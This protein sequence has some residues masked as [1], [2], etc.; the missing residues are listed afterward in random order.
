MG[1]RSTRLVSRMGL[2][3]LLTL[4]LLPLGPMSALAT[5]LRDPMTIR[6]NASTGNDITGTGTLAAPYATI[7]K[8]MTVATVVGDVVRVA[9]GTYY[10]PDTITIPTGVQL[11]GA[12]LGR[13]TVVGVGGPNGPMFRIFNGDSNTRLEGFTV[14]GGGGTNGG[15][16]EILGGAS[17]GWGP[18]ITRNDFADCGVSESGGAIF[19]ARVTAAYCKPQIFTNTFRG[20]EASQNGGAICAMDGADPYIYRCTFSGN[21][22]SGSGTQ[23]GGAIYLSGCKARIQRCDIRGNHAPS[24]SG[25]GIAVTT[26]G[27]IVEITETVVYANSA[28]M[29][30]GIWVN[31]APFETVIE[32]CWIAANSG[33]GLGGGMRIYNAPV[34]IDGCTFVGNRKVGGGS[35]GAISIYDL[36]ADQPVTVTSSVFH[37]NGGDDVPPVS[38]FTDITVTYS[39]L[40]EA[41]TGTGNLSG[42]DPLLTRV[43]PYLERLDTTSSCIDAGDPAS[44]L[45][46]DLQMLPRP[47]DG[48]DPDA[49]ARVDMGHFEFGTTIG[50]L[51]GADRFATSV[52]SIQGRFNESPVAVI[53]TGRDFPDALCAAGLAG[54]FHAPVLLTDTNALPA[55][56]AEALTLQEIREAIIVGGTGVVGSAVETQLQELGIDVT[57]I[58]GVDRYAT[59]RAV[60]DYMATVGPSLGHDL[61]RFCWVARGDMFPDALALAPLAAL[62]DAPGPVLLTRPDSLPAPVAGALSTHVYEHALVAGGISAVSDAVYGQIAA[63][64]PGADIDRAA[65]ADRYGTAAA[66]A[67]WAMGADFTAGEF[68]GIATGADFPDALSGGAACGYERGILLL[69]PA[70]TLDAHAAAFLADHTVA[71]REIYVFGGSGVVSDAVLASCETIAP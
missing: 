35:P 26:P 5:P 1:R 56:V 17:P 39:Y 55:S 14:R 4:G 43:S 42:A 69:T 64:I 8:A 53:A 7:E 37:D 28:D 58:A 61:T 23:G 62:R 67:E 65:G 24:G 18:I 71:L 45:D 12:G 40:N 22:A 46:C 16:V 34:H 59:S 52:A 49:T 44:T 47:K 38:T 20:N 19:I 21:S 9:P 51:A 29:G 2:S 6:V 66:V 27:G 48:P 30:G 63:M 60:A 54:A 13:T 36:D 3:V 25:G 50:R 41:V 31:A 33:D 68:I 10:P 70:N 32:N 15:A 11:I 57:R